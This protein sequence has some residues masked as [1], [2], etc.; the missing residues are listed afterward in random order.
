MAKDTKSK[1][2]NNNA[3]QVKSPIERR[4][5]RATNLSTLLL[6]LLTLVIGLS[7]YTVSLIDHYVE[8]SSSIAQSA[9]PY[10]DNVVDVEQLTNDVTAVY[11]NLESGKT[12]A[13]TLGGYDGYYRMLLAKP[14]FKQL[15]TMLSGFC[16][17]NDVNDVYLGT[18]D[19]ERNRLVYICDPDPDETT[20]FYPGEW[21]VVEQSEIDKYYNW[22]GEGNLYDISY[23]KRY[24]FIFRNMLLR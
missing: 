22:N 21:E 24:G 3:M 10:I 12:D 8:D 19:R 16:S 2:Q 17:A 4:V 7:L 1:S 20:R 13:H 6:G 15:N 14:D 18:F 9:A 23:M 5:L 11:N